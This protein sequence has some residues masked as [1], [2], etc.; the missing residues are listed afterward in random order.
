MS[1]NTVF[2]ILAYDIHLQ[3]LR[4]K[5][6][7][8]CI[9]FG[10]KRVNRSVFEGDLPQKAFSKRLYPL[11]TMLRKDDSILIYTVNERILRSKEIFVK[12]VKGRKANEA[13]IF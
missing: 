10:L 9:E 4:T 6:S 8:L 1:D 13:V 12:R 3:K 2:V 5:L 11:L 7:D